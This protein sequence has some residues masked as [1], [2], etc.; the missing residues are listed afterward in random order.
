M[1]ERGNTKH[2]AQRDDELARETEDLV[3][4]EPQ[5]GHTEEWR[6][7]EPVDDPREV[8]EAEDATLTEE[9]AIELRSE[10]ARLLTR[11]EFPLTRHALLAILE[12]KDASAALVERV[13]ALP[14][15]PHY[16]S[17][18]ELIEALGLADAEAG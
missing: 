2:G 7:T 17:T 3:R 15:R 14:G 8:F 11:D 5:V 18:H 4:A 6:E 1:M 10:L 13:S 9:Q 16:Q 12:A